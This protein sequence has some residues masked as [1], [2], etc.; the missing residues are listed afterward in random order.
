MPTHETSIRRAG[1]ALLVGSMLLTG[2]SAA[3]PKDDTPGGKDYTASNP[4][5]ATYDFSNPMQ[6][7]STEI[8][9]EIGESLAKA[10]GP[11]VDQL[12]VKKFKLT[13]YKLD[14][15]QYC[16]ATIEFEWSG[17]LT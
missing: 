1:A 5:A 4:A 3:E 14:T 10:I 17:L 16:A 15:A 8:T 9:V 6:G 11:K 2:C 7:P 13:P 12:P